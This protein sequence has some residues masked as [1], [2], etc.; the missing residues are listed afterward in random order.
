MVCSV[1]YRD[2]EGYFGMLAVHPI[3]HGQGVGN[4]L[5]AHAEETM[6]SE[7]LQ[8]STCDVVTPIPRLQGYYERR[9]YQLTGEKTAWSSENLKQE[10][11]FLRMKKNLM[12]APISP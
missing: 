6:K 2:S 1:E 4:L 9:G 3:L 8:A 7:G 11:W 5:L 12:E 10:A